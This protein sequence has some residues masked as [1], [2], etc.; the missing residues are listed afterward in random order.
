MDAIKPKEVW[1]QEESYRIRGCIY[2]VNKK[3]G[4][5]FLEAVY[6]EAVGIELEKAK[7]PFDREESHPNNVRWESAQTILHSRF[8]LLRENHHRN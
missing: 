3:L 8:C 5:G 4:S 6:Q 2:E 7:I 1:Y